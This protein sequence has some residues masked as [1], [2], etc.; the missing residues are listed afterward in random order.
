MLSYLGRE[1][2]E[3]RGN[4]GGDDIY[5]GS[6][7]KQYSEPCILLLRGPNS[8]DDQSW[9]CCKWYA[10]VSF[11]FEGHSP[12]AQEFAMVWCRVMAALFR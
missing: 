5:T 8:R 6:G 3:F 12:A 2:C 1:N 10:D 7:W 11:A 4:F 9:C